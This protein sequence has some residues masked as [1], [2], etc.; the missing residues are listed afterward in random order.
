MQKKSC[1]EKSASV[2]KP[3]VTRIGEASEPVT[4]GFSPDLSALKG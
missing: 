3:S 1:Q 4:Q 2:G